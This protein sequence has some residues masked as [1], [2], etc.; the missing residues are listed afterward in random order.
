MSSDARIKPLAVIANAYLS[1]HEKV[2]LRAILFGSDPTTA[3][4]YIANSGSRW[5]NRSTL[6]DL[7]ALMGPVVG[8]LLLSLVNGPASDCLTW[9]L[10]I[11]ALSVYRLN[12][13]LGGI[14]R[15][16]IRR[17]REDRA[18]ER[19]MA[20]SVIAYAEPMVIFAVLHGVLSVRLKAI[21]GVVGAGYSLGGRGWNWV[22]MLHMSVACYTTAGWGDVSPTSPSTMLLSDIEAVV[23]ILM[24]ALTISTFVSRALDHSTPE[25]RG[26]SSA[27]APGNQGDAAHGAK[28]AARDAS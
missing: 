22:T 28:E 12:E 15:V 18:D 16:V 2:S 10:C 9:A 6:V 26:T 11:G 25:A 21:S 7:Y 14:L 8:F 20:M 4:K 13:L 24:L 19:K 5:L 1:V 27:P 17:S 23:G 3:P